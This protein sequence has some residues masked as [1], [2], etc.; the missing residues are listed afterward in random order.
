MSLPNISIPA[1]NIP[2]DIPTLLHPALVHFAIAIP[3]LVVIAEILNLMIKGRGIKIVS[4]L[5]MFLLIV[6]LFGAYLTGTTD[7]KAAIDSGFNAM[8][9]LKEHKLLGIYLFYGSIV[10]F[11]LKLLSLVINKTG[12]RVFYILVLFGFLAGIIHQGK[13]GGELVYK[14]GAN[15]QVKSDEFDDD[16]EIETK[17]VETKK[18]E[19]NEDKKDDTTTNKENTTPTNDEAQSQQKTIEQES[20]KEEETS[21]NKEIKKEEEKTTTIDEKVEEKKDE[22]EK[23][24]EEANEKIKKEVKQIDKTVK[25]EVEKVNKEIKEVTNPEKN[26]H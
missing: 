4:S 12:F 15:V 8:E 22:V 19:E 20:K 25:E 11:V 23:K 17:A 21:Q 1:V 16:E 18:V 7:G 6:I 14:Y 13:E 24:V 3:V 5:M 9:E 10:I 26:E 2:F